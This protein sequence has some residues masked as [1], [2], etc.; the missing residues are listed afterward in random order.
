MSEPRDSPG[1]VVAVRGLGK[2][3]GPLRVLRAVSLEVLAGRTL[4]VLGPSGS[5]KS[6]LLRCINFLERPDEGAVFLRGERVG[7]CRAASGWERPMTDRELARM[8]TRFGMVFQQFNLWPHLTVMGN[9]VESPLHVQRR[10][11]DEVA[12][13]AE[14]LLEK[15][16]LR[17]K[18]D[19][20]PSR[21]SGGQKQRVAIAA[22][23]AMTPTLMVLDEPT[24]SL[25][26][27]GKGE[28]FA[29]VRS[30][31]Q[32]RSMTI[33]MVEHESEQ[34]AEFADRVVVLREGQVELEGT[35]TAVFAQTERMRDI[36]LAVPQ[37]SELAACLN[38]QRRKR[39]AFTRLE[40]AAKVL[41]HDLSQARVHSS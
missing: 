25:D 36:G 31:R 28:V 3:F 20:Y 39:F 18:R 33:V 14:A 17:D 16:G 7:F 9:L 27:R 21:L 29:I 12:A 5:G 32:Q 22:I 23:L 24:A 2:S 15:I 8:R 38:R 19:A 30:L 6:T 1:P 40:E 4:C 11:R 10:P 35:P 26:P 13:E 34:I 37:V 41:A